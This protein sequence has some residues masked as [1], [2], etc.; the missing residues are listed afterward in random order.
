[1]EPEPTTTVVLTPDGE[2]ECF[3]DDGF[4]PHI[5]K[6]G[7]HQRSDIALLRALVREGDLI[8]DVG[9]FIGTMAVPLAKAV[10]SSG[11]LIAFEPVPKHAALLRKNLRRNGLIDR[12]EVVEALIGR[13]Q[14]GT[15]SAQRLPLSAATTWFGPCEEGDGTAV[16]TLDD[17]ATSKSLE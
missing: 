12:S 3:T 4:L 10:G 9:A 8:L 5:Q 14:S 17:W 11:S 7:T 1:M 6:F 15:F 13:E 16:L 2:I